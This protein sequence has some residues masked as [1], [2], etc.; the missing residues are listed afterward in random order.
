MKVAIYAR[1][2]TDKCEICGK[3][4]ALHPGLGHEF[5]GQD[6]EVQLREL[7]EWCAAH[8]HSIVGEYVD[9]GLSGKKGVVRPELNRLLEHAE[10][11]HRDFAGVLVWRLSRF[12]RSFPDLI[13]NVAKLSEAKIDFLSKQESF[14]LD[15]TMGRFAFRIMCA[16]VEMERE[17][18]SENTRAGMK[19]ARSQ[20]RIPGPKIDPK[21]G[22]S[23][24][25]ERRRRLKLEKS[26]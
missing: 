8:N 4:P 23:R 6:P 9:R 22:P 3:K 17:V 13:A 18:I 15:T 7:R 14:Q 19:L 12:G 24:W 16:A 2:S 25:T 26:A 20:G 1:V 21:K 11:G 5:R 10:K